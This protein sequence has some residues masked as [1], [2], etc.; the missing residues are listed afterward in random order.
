MCVLNRENCKKRYFEN[1]KICSILTY[2]QKPILTGKFEKCGTII[3]SQ[4]A[5]PCSFAESGTL[6]RTIRDKISGCT[7]GRSVQNREGKGIYLGK[8]VK[9]REGKWVR[10]GK[11]RQKWR[12]RLGR[13][14][15]MIIIDLNVLYRTGAHDFFLGFARIDSQHAPNEVSISA[16]LQGAAFCKHM[17]LPYFV[18]LPVST[19]STAFCNYP[20]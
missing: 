11:K 19:Q 6:P 1:K 15:R 20:F 9:N 3:C 13:G 5:V 16:K 7:R 17:I 4:K 18:N 10:L 12:M 8:S 2:L 14:L